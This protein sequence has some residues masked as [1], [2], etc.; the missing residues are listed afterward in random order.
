MAIEQRSTIEDMDLLPPK[1][2]CDNPETSLVPYRVTHT[3]A[4]PRMAAVDYLKSAGAK[5]VRVH[6][7]TGPWPVD[8]PGLIMPGE[9]GRAV[10]AGAGQGISLP[11]T[12]RNLPLVKVFW[13]MRQF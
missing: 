12:G 1:E 7:S 2:L 8:A 13:W 6:L 11:H 4:D 5:S 10:I 3:T 9:A